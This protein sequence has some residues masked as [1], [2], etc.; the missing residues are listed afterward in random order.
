MDWLPGW[1]PSI[2]AS[3]IALLVVDLV[4]RLT[5]IAVVPVNR[6]PSSALAWLLTI[7]FIPY[8]GVVAFLIIGNPK[9]PRKRRRKQREINELIL[10]STK[11]MD[12]VSSDHPWPPWLTGIVELNRNLG[13]M[14]LVGG[15]QAQLEGSTTR[16]SG[17]W[18]ARSTA[19]ATTCT[20]SSTS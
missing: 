2:T 19:L 7:F 5:A 9:L 11:G 12:L 4:V 10:S 14:P 17:R 16:R 18:R 8:I 3:A 15:N 6:R 20:S 1:I 13:A